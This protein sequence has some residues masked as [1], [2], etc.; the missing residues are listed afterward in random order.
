M[1]PDINSKLDDLVVQLK[2]RIATMQSNG[3]TVKGYSLHLVAHTTIINGSA[4][5]SATWFDD[6]PAEV[7]NILNNI[8]K[9]PNP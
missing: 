5:V 9:P 3:L 4:T 7:Q 2:N 6:P 1:R 8:N